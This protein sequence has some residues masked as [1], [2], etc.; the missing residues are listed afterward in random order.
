LINVINSAGGSLD[1]A[2]YSLTKPN[3]VNSILTA[4][5]RGVSV[6]IITDKEESSSKSQERELNMLSRA[7]IPTKINSHQGLMHLKVTIADDSTV[8]A[9]SY[10]YTDEATYDNDEVLV[11]IRSPSMW[12]DTADYVEQYLAVLYD[13]YIEGERAK[14]GLI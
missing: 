14:I 7:G 9:G 6:R 8:T 5:K 12:A 11:I 10:N 13:R 4:K 1:I 2:I 3:I